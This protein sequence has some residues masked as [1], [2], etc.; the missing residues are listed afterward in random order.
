MSR[1][2]RAID[3]RITAARLPLPLAYGI[4]AAA[5]AL[6]GGIVAVAVAHPA[7]II[8]VLV[9]GIIGGAIGLYR[10]RHPNA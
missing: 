2:T 4:V 9:S 7:Y 1:L 8:V 6:I 3:S 5:L 10:E